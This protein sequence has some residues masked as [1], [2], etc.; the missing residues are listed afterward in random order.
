MNATT[1]PQPRQQPPQVT[2]SGAGGNSVPALPSNIRSIL[3]TVA[4]RSL[5]IRLTEFPVIFATILPSLFMVQALADWIFNFSWWIRLVLLLGDAAVI[6]MLLQKHVLLPFRQRLN[7]RTAALLVERTVPQFHSSLISAVELASGHSDVAQSSFRLVNILLAQVSSLVKRVDILSEVIQTKVLKQ[8]L[9]WMALVLLITFSAGYFFYPKSLIMIRRLVLFNDALPTLTVVEAIT[10]DVIIPSG[11]DF[12]LVARARGFV[13]RKGRL[14]LVHE[15]GRR[16]TIPVEPETTNASVFAFRLKNVRQNFRYH[17][18]LHDGVGVEYKAAVHS[19]PSLSQ[20][21]FTQHY[22]A[23][24]ELKETD[25]A[26]NNLAL[27]VGGDL[28]INGESNK[29]LKSATLEIKGTDQKIPMDIS[30]SD[31]RLLTTL[32]P[33]RQ[34]P[35]TGISIHL[36]SSDGDNSVNDPVYPVELLVDKPPTVSIVA[37]QQDK[38]TVL[39]DAKVPVTFTARD[40]Y[41]MGYIGFYYEV[42]PPVQ[43]LAGKNA[44][45]EQFANP[46]QFIANQG[47]LAMDVPRNENSFTHTFVFDLGKIVPVPAIGSTITYRIQVYD[48][49]GTATPGIGVSRRKI[50]EVVSEETKKTELLEAIAEKAAE[51]DRIYKSEHSLNEKTQSTLRIN[52]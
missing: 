15:D 40:D 1:S 24:T 26:G 3:L 13:P 42:I 29:P 4:K 39:P 43:S 30:G 22:P 44:P 6:G 8:R 41:R 47:N 23:Y 19:L 34:G 27:L 33:I 37:P 51:L 9:K 18:E 50:L 52:P 28:R 21:Q 20:T 14:I 32:M 35:I 17:F 38:M 31:K 5:I 48:N 46:E 36:V 25:M 45:P 2:P 16:E 49:N 11:S 10:K 7:I 12:E